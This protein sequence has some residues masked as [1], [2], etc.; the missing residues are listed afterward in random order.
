MANRSDLEENSLEEKLITDDSN[1]PHF[2]N[3]ESSVLSSESDS[4]QSVGSANSATYKNTGIVNKNSKKKTR[5]REI[6]K[7]L[8]GFNFKTSKIGSKLSSHFLY[9]GHTHNTP[10]R[11]GIKNSPKAIVLTCN[12][13][14]RPISGNDGNSMYNFIRHLEVNVQFT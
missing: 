7:P 6:P 13:C 3:S 10:G 5:V 11:P 8:E 14:S 2:G 12:R 4:I 9:T 1:Q